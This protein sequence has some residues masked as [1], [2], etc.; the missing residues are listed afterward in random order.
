MRVLRFGG[1]GGKLICMNTIENPMQKCAKCPC[2]LTLAFFV[3]CDGQVVFAP[4]LEGFNSPGVRD[5]GAAA[6]FALGV[7]GPKNVVLQQFA[8]C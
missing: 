7:V 6:W 4:S 1:K 5:R 8:A 3:L 2:W